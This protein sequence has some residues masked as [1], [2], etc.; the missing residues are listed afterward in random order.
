MLFER[1]QYQIEAYSRDDDWQGRARKRQSDFREKILKVDAAPNSFSKDGTPHYYGNM[2]TKEAAAEGKNFYGPVWEKIKNEK[3]MRKTSSPICTN[4]LR[5]E[6]IPYNVFFPMKENLR[7]ATRLFQ[8][9]TGLDLVAVTDIRIEWPEM[10]RGET[11]IYI[12]DRTCFDTFVEYVDSQGKTCGIGIEVK[13]TE[14]SYKIGDKERKNIENRDS[15]YHKVTDRSGIFDYKG[16]NEY[17]FV[18]KEL[19]KDKFRQIWRNHILGLGMVQKGDLSHFLYIHL[20]PEFNKHFN[21]VIPEYQCLLSEEGM[22]TFLPL[23]YE[24]LFNAIEKA[25]FGKESDNW[26]KYLRERYIID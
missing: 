11:N 8:A 20:Y 10:R 2:I 21:E 15:A 23:T 24:R 12:G 17:D 13:Y 14:K 6:H 19:S 26:I 9:L 25:N 4:L 18:N 3:K 16:S 5:S 22:K 7:A 1:K